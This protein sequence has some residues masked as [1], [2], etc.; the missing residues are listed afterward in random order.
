[1]DLTTMLPF[2]LINL[3]MRHQTLLPKI[4]SVNT[5]LIRTEKISQEL[6]DVY[7]FSIVSFLFEKDFFLK[8][9]LLKNVAFIFKF[10]IKVA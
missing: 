8:K 9:R 4:F 3:K 6:L 1:M 5:F 10:H 2:C 7:N